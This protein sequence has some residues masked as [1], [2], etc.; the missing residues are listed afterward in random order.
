MSSAVTLTSQVSA[1]GLSFK[2]DIT[3]QMTINR[4]PERSSR[5]QDSTSK[6]PETNTRA[7]NAI[8]GTGVR[9]RTEATSTNDLFDDGR[10]FEESVAAPAVTE[11]IRLEPR[12][13]SKDGYPQVAGVFCIGI[14]VGALSLCWGVYIPRIVDDMSTSLAM[15]SFAGGLAIGLIGTSFASNVWELYVFYGLMVGMGLSLMLYPGSYI[16]IQWYRKR[17]ATMLGIALA[18]MGVG[19]FLYNIVAAELIDRFGWRDTLRMT[20]VIVWAFLSPGLLLIRDRVPPRNVSTRLDWHLFRDVRFFLVFLSNILFSIGYAAPFFFTVTWAE[21]HGMSSTVAAIATGVIAVCAGLGTP[22]QGW[23]GDRTSRDIVYVVCMLCAGAVLFFNVWELYIFYGLMVGMGLSLL[24][25]PGSYI[26]IQWYRKKK[27][28][29]LGFGLGSLGIGGFVYNVV[30]SLLINQYGWRDALRI[31][32]LPVFVFLVVGLL[33]IRDRVPPRR[34]STRLDWH[35][36]RDV[37]FFLVFLCNAFFSFGYAAPFFFTVTWAERH[38]LSSTVAAIATGFIAISTGLGTP[39]Q[40]WIGDRTARD[41]VFVVCMLCA[42]AVLFLWPICVTEWSLLLVSLLYGFVTG[43][44]SAN[45]AAIITDWFP[46]HD[47]GKVNGLSGAGRAV[48]ELFGPVLIAMLFDTSP[49]AAFML[50]GAFMMFT[51]IA[52]YIGSIWPKISNGS[53]LDNVSYTSVIRRSESE[54]QQGSGDLAMTDIS[55]NSNP[56]Q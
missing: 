19:G 7:V 16:I 37:R 18:S 6:A 53:G 28:M 47:P 36:F 35:L 21:R 42:G 13:D 22:A 11:G 4:S 27:A 40:G 14:V 46:R 2:D 44:Q 10:R 56:I 34:V 48:G 38:N 17:K 49:E 55:R 45:T 3:R 32:V 43:G 26:I 29:M 15:A 9:Q 25:Y 8:D 33:L 52:I 23:I 5:S 24:L 41:I 51:G 20:V 31:T 30:A 50:S 1:P 54:E 12:I 39:V